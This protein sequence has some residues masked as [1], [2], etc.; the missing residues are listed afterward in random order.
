MAESPDS[1]SRKFARTILAET[2]QVR[3][4]DNV[5]IEAWS[6]ALPWAVPFVNETRRLGARPVLLY[7][8][9]AAYWEALRNGLARA[10]GEVGEHEWGL[11]ENSDAYVFFFGP[12]AWP[13]YDE[14]SPSRALAEVTRYNAEWYRR[15]KKARIRG[16]RI[17][18]GRTSPL[19]AE[20]WKVDL[21]SWRERLLRA[22]LASP[23]AMHRL[24]RRVGDRLREG[25]H[26]HLTHP[27]GTDLEFRLGRFPVQIDDAYVDE[28]DLRAGNNLATIPGGVVG[29][30]VDHRSASGRAIGDQPVFYNGGRADGLRWSFQAGR[31]I[32]RAFSEGGPEFEA[33]FSAAPKNGRD[34]LSSFS[35]GL[36]PDLENLP[37]LE[38]QEL[39][40]VLLRIGGNTFMGGR[41]ASPFSAWLALRGAE[42]TIDDRPLLRGGKFV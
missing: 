11:L 32:D 39:G 10:T 42:V 30:A 7:E 9:E 37:Q 41:N 17:Y 4:G 21:E 20:R 22:S 16:A 23:R 26:V 35:I 25:T 28:D 18:L 33:R 19:S 31:L 12:A 3:R 5:T 2:L 29:V 36:N 1:L 24:G 6:E 8:D 40:T 27:N 14:I 34:R 13:R 38:D 15:A